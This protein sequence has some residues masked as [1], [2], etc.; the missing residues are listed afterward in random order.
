MG[1]PMYPSVQHVAV[2][3]LL[4]VGAVRPLWEASHALGHAR[5]DVSAAS[6]ELHLGLVPMH[7]RGS[8]ERAHGHEHPD[9]LGVLLSQRPQHDMPAA[10]L[11]PAAP[12]ISV[13]PLRLTSGTPSA[14]ARASP[15]CIE[16]LRPRAPPQH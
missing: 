12:E 8:A 13:I 1:A 3:V 9:D 4:L 2:A 15:R 10:A 14:G 7:A 16:A 11:L 6:V 5:L